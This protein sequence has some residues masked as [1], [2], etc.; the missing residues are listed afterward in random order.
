MKEISSIASN[1]M[2]LPLAN[3]QVTASAELVILTTEPTYNMGGEEIVKARPL[4]A[5]RVCVD[6]K[7][8]GGMIQALQNLG[9]ELEKMQAEY[10]SKLPSKPVEQAFLVYGKNVSGKFDVWRDHDDG[11][12]R[13]IGTFDSATD[14]KAHIEKTYPNCT[15]DTP[16]PLNNNEDGIMVFKVTP[17]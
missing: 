15:V 1:L 10:N 7:A 3:G 14:A 5:V 9:E 2:L 17:K 11:M 6:L 16:L 8:V 12:A 13:G 4:E